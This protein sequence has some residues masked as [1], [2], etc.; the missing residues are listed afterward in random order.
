MAEINGT[1]IL[2]LFLVLPADIITLAADQSWNVVVLSSE[3]ST[4]DSIWQNLRCGVSCLSL[5]VYLN[6]EQFPF[7]YNE[8]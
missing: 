2:K 7:Q 3:L 6:P 4:V 1:I 5:I 8:I